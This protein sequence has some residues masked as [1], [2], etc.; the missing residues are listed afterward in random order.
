MEKI[1][2]IKKQKT[3]IMTYTYIHK[4]IYFFSNE[5]NVKKKK[6]MVFNKHLEFQK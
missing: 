6:K 4:Q 3:Y 1:K 2:I 5:Y